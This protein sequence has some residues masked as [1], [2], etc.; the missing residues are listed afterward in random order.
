M[1]VCK[2]MHKG[3]SQFV[4][5]FMRC[6]WQNAHACYTVSRMEAHAEA[7]A[8]TPQIL[9]GEAQHEALMEL[10]RRAR[11]ALSAFL[12]ISPR[13]KEDYRSVETVFRPRS[14]VRL[15]V[16][17]LY[18]YQKLIETDPVLGYLDHGVKISSTGRMR[19]TKANGFGHFHGPG[20]S[21]C[22]VMFENGYVRHVYDGDS[23]L[24]THGRGNVYPRENDPPTVGM[25]QGKG[26]KRE[27]GM[28]VEPSSYTEPTQ[29]SLDHFLAS[30]DEMKGYLEA[31]LAKQEQER[32]AIVEQPSQQTRNPLYDLFR[33]FWRG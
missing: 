16:N 4:S 21:F 8:H 24:V 6:P 5:S 30:L 22:D 7:S 11:D 3:F 10:H 31:E 18:H 15:Q 29:E 9:T 25:R 17:D 28:K 27:W 20:S 19:L 23:E 14:D 32:A 33:R 12:K 13:P 1:L 2:E 26:L